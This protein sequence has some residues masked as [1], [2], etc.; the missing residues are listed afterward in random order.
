MS[1][2]KPC[3]FCGSEVELEKMPLWYGSRGYKDCYEFKICCKKCGC[4]VNQP[5][6]DTVYR[7]E[8]IAKENAIRAW[9]IR[10]GEQA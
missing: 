3:P 2:L 10:V 5:Q 9:N 1:E 4:N 7:S 8:T 6:N